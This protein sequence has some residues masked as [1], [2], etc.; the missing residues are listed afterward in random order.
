MSITG[1]SG[2]RKRTQ[3]HPFLTVGPVAAVPPEPRAQRAQNALPMV[4]FIIPSK[5][6]FTTGRQTPGGRSRPLVSPVLGKEGFGSGRDFPVSLPWRLCRA[7]RSRPGCPRR[8]RAAPGWPPHL[9]APGTSLPSVHVSPGRGISAAALQHPDHPQLCC[10]FLASFSPED[11]L[12]GHEGCKQGSATSEGEASLPNAVYVSQAMSL[13]GLAGLTCPSLG[14]SLWLGDGCCDWQS[15]EHR[16]QGRRPQLP[17]SG[18]GGQ[19]WG[20]QWVSPAVVY[21]PLG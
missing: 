4:A 19:G 6:S 21:Q 11:L 2:P 16:A 18:W 10:L 5:S 8:S 7:S 12:H 3:A 17:E 14:Q 20:N 15:P 13:T 9:P 1:A